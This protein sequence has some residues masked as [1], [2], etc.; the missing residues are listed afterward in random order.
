MSHARERSGE[1]RSGIYSPMV[2]AQNTVGE[3]KWMGEGRLVLSL[4][5]NLSARG[6]IIRLRSRQPTDDG[7]LVRFLDLPGVGT[8]DSIYSAGTK[9]VPNRES[10]PRSTNL[11]F[12]SFSPYMSV[13]EGGK[14]NDKRLLL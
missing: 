9:P 12:L 6:C 2:T 13:R 5:Y 3:Q 1:T 4:S 8:S 7:A 11:L 14:P 10:Y